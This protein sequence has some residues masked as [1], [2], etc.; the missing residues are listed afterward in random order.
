MHLRGRERFPRDSDGVQ[1]PGPA[2]GDGRCLFRA[3]RLAEQNGAAF[4][5]M[6]KESLGQ[7]CRLAERGIR[8]TRRERQQLGERV[9]LCS[10][11]RPSLEEDIL[12]GT[13]LPPTNL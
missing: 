13:S 9:G 4:E 3:R 8:V 2:A 1:Q 12:T 5:L 6:R 7:P 10:R 11:V